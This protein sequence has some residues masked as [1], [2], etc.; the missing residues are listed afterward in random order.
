MDHTDLFAGY[1]DKKPMKKK[2]Y[3]VRWCEFVEYELE[4]EVDSPEDA[5]GAAMDKANE[6][7]L[8][9]N[10]ELGIEPDSI[11]IYEVKE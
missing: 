9:G 4:V 11:E 2:K 8:E 3:K 1:E 10:H 5:L 7:D 6:L